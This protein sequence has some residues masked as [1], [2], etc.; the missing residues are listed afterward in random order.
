L[1]SRNPSILGKY[2][3]Q[4]TDEIAEEAKSRKRKRDGDGD[5]EGGYDGD[6]DELICLKDMYSCHPQPRAI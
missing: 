6:V 2:I 5:N 4:A 3:E 1:L